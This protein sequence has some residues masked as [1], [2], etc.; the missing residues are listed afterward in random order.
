MRPVPVW[1]RWMLNPEKREKLF[2]ALFFV[3]ILVNL[4]IVAGFILF[5]VFFLNR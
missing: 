4:F 5:I 3:M 2:K 1:E